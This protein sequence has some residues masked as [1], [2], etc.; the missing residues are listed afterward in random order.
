MYGYVP[1]LRRAP[2]ESTDCKFSLG[3]RT[4]FVAVYCAQGSNL[5]LI[6]G[7]RVA[8]E[9]CHEKPGANGTNPSQLKVCLRDC[10]G[11]LQSGRLAAMLRRK[12][13]DE[14]KRVSL[15]LRMSPN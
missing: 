6:K 9:C 2:C 7:S 5:P 12:S 13:V 1:Q 15:Q 11:R 3:E 4:S 8:A 10:A 14:L